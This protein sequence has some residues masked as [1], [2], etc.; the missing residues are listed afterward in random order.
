MSSTEEE[1]P[2]SPEKLEDAYICSRSQ[3]SESPH[4]VLVH[5]NDH[6][7]LKEVV[8]KYSVQHTAREMN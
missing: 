8:T 7:L 1:A 2:V 4:F 6:D 3:L 5:L